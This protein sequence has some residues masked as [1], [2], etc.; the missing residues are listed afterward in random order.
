MYY[1]PPTSEVVVLFSTPHPWKR[2]RSTLI[3][4]TS[5]LH[6]SHCFESSFIFAQGETNAQG[7][8]GVEKGREARFA[9]GKKRGREGQRRRERGRG[10]GGVGRESLSIP[11]HA[12]KRACEYATTSQPNSPHRRTHIGENLGRNGPRFKPF[13]PVPAGWW[14]LTSFRA[15]ARLPC[16]VCWVF[17]LLGE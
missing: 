6:H 13:F 10:D 2:W 14:A 3:G 15:W 12:R 11:G 9:R 7:Q 4:R 5:P 17:F 8:E 1:D 16:I